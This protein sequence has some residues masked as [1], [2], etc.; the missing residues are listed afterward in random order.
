MREHWTQ[1]YG[2]G[3]LMLVRHPLDN[4][5][6]WISSGCPLN[7]HAG[8]RVIAQRDR[9]NGKTA[10]FKSETTRHNGAHREKRSVRPWPRGRRIRSVSQYVYSEGTGHCP[11][12][13]MDQTLPDALVW[14]R[15]GYKAD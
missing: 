4:H 5:S 9:E 14:L 8:R 12:E 6:R 10:M 15:R 1:R 2:H 3:A 13:V 11:G 7:E